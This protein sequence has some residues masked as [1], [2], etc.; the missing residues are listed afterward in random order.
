MPRHR[1]SRPRRQRGAA[2][3]LVLLVAITLGLSFLFSPS[4]T[5]TLLAS[6]EQQSANALSQ[7][8]EAIVGKA[9]TDPSGGI[10]GL[11]QLPDLGSSRNATAQEGVG[12]GSFAGNTA[13]LS[14]IGRL[15]WFTLGLPVLKDANGECLWYAVS[16]S[17][18]S[19]QIPTPFN[20][21]TIGHFDTH[22]S[23]GT[24]AGTQ[25]TAG[26]NYHNRPLAIVFSAGPPLAGQNRQPSSTDL[27][28]NCGGNY[29]VKNYLDSYTA[30]ANVNGIV[31]YFAGTT[32]NSTGD[33]SALLTP[34]AILAGDV[35]VASGSEKVRLVN[36]RLLPITAKEIFDRVKKRSEF[37]ASLDEMMSRLQNCLDA[38][39][40]VSASANNKGIENLTTSCRPK[41]PPAQQVFFDHWQ[42]NLLYAGGASGNFTISNTGEACKGLLFFAGERTTRTVAPLTAQIRATIAQRGNSTT[43]GDPAM[44]LEGGNASSFPANGTA[45]SGASYFS[46]SNASADIV[47]CIRGIAGTTPISFPDDLA[48]A[49]PTGPSGAAAANVDTTEQTVTIVDAS[50]IGNACLW[51]PTRIPLSGKTLRAYYQFQFAYPDTYA[52]TGA[53]A[54]RGNGFTLQFVRGDILNAFG[55]PL[56]PNNCGTESNLGA[57]G[58]ADVWGS[59]SYIVE[60]DVRRTSTQS[61]PAGN[62]TAILTNGS[63]SHTGLVPTSA[64]NGS[65]NG[66]LHSPA[67]TFEEA[68][69]PLLHN[70]RIE[71]HTGCSAT[72]DQC[73]PA[74]SGDKARI[75]V[76]VDCTD[77][78]NVTTDH[79]DAELIVKAENRLFT[80]NGDWTGSN[81]TVFA[82]TLA[83]SAGNNPAILPNSALSSAPAAGHSYRV[84]LNVTTATAGKIAVS[85]GGKTTG[86]MDQAA[87]ASTNYQLQ[88]EASNADPLT[89]TPDATWTGSIAQVSVR[90]S[91]QPTISRCVTLHPELHQVFV[92]FTGGFLSTSDA[93]QGITI[94]NFSLRSE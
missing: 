58:T 76:W 93:T 40:P 5:A 60:T 71:I 79:V 84:S 33:A 67:N 4:N 78:S 85:L 66:C 77:C 56:F 37:K 90:A 80:G 74:S 68:P 46:A 51:F 19:A 75:S 7:A 6:R 1:R 17:A 11:L 65:S 3:L 70:Q 81:W 54:D 10:Y 88:F 89:L 35:D 16:G 38:T 36:D 43:P 86:L 29:D 62:H 28:A 94:R 41:L 73:N 24:P 25:S 31:N 45:Y 64:C 21:D 57:L 72:C 82:N 52:T 14:V 22:R 20:W 50:G 13:G 47:R 23:D 39:A 59:F 48:G 26:A 18:Q 30:N 83:H 34:K 91:R 12:A 87:G 27:V 61:D 2:L 55:T 9:V 63:L 44:Y 49:V 42:D 32:N 53:T 15:P 92:G 8:K 69:T